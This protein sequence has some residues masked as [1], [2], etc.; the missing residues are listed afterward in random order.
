MTMEGAQQLSTQYW[1]EE[2]VLRTA[3]R[4]ACACGRRPV[5]DRQ[6]IVS[7]IKCEVVHTCP[8]T[9]RVTSIVHCDL[10]CLVCDDVHRFGVQMCLPG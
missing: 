10:K 5:A 9:D 4:S 8:I 1:T 3:A 2:E 7:P 6:E